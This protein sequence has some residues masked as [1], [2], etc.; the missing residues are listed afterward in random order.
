[1]WWIQRFTSQSLFSYSLRVCNLN[2]YDGLFN[3]K[4]NTTISKDLFLCYDR[5]SLNQND[6]VFLE[7]QNQNINL[8]QE[9]EMKT[10]LDMKH[11]SESSDEMVN[12]KTRC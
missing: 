3:M 6:R 12:E 4:S 9:Y 7:K 5:T 11:D 1:M 10:S 8:G 2:D